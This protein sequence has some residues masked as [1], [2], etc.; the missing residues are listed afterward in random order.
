MSYR[1]LAWA[2][3]QK[4]GSTHAYAVLCALASY[5]NDDCICWPSQ[6]RL[7]E[8]TSQSDRSVRSQ[9]QFLIESG[10][11]EKSG[12][13]EYRLLIDKK[14]ESLSQ[15]RKQVPD[16]QSTKP[17]TGSAKPESLSQKPETGS[18]KSVRTSKEPVKKKNIKKKISRPP[19][20]GVEVWDDFSLHRKAKKAELT[21]TALSRIR[22]EAEKAGWSLEAA[23]AECCARGWQGFKAEWVREQGHES[24]GKRN[25]AAFDKPTKSDILDQAA[26]E[27]LAEL[28]Y[29]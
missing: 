29:F 14:P 17:E 16:S 4:T 6:E 9:I 7:A 19:D 28:G 5:A 12:A 22:S 24:I 8:Q 23:L 27:S 25:G 2:A 1:A 18:Y 11:I 26:R 13:R 15:N 10:F 21:E 20:V 3:V